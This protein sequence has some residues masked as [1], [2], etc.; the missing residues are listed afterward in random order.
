MPDS[1]VGQEDY[2]NVYI[3]L[4]DSSLENILKHIK[5]NV[6]KDVYMP[7]LKMNRA[8]QKKVNVK[9]I[10]DNEQK[11]GKWRYIFEENHLSY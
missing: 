5:N 7:L 3:T 1:N 8:L 4:I 10:S 11:N 6:N 9:L 2:D